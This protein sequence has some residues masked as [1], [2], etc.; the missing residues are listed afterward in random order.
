MLW[1]I[2]SSHLNGLAEIII[3]SF[4][5]DNFPYISIQLPI[6]LSTVEYI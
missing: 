1:S 3:I 2:H 4:L 6:P 5:V